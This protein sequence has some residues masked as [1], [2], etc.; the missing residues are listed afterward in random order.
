MIDSMAVEVQPARN[1]PEKWRVLSSCGQSIEGVLIVGDGVVAMP[2][3]P[4][5]RY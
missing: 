4:W 3:Q 5:A 2:W 1:W